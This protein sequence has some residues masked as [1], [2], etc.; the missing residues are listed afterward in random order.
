MYTNDVARMLCKP[1]CHIGLIC[2]F[3]RNVQDKIRGK[4]SSFLILG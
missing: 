1:P 3:I 2:H 4:Y